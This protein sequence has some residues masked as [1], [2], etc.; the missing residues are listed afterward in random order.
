LHYPSIQGEI[1]LREL[2]FEG[3]FQSASNR[4]FNSR[5]SKAMMDRWMSR[6]GDL[7]A[8]A[9]RIQAIAHSRLLFAARQIARKAV[10][11]AANNGRELLNH[12]KDL[13]M[14][15][16]MIRSS[17]RAVQLRLVRGNPLA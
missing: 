3:A 17:L 5:M 14:Q 11:P 9:S 4:V 10:L 15:L 16:L 8:I 1:E 6:E 2:L 13:Y 12:K 7:L